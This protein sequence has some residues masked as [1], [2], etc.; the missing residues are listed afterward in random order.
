MTIMERVRCLL[1]HAKLPKIFWGE[2]LSTVVHVLNLTPCVPLKFDIT[3][4]IWSGK[5]VSYGH[6]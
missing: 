5:N 4:R 3:E 2:A 6:L 1:S